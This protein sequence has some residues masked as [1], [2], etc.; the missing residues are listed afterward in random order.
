MAERI[1]VV[2]DEV[3]LADILGKYLQ[4]SGYEV[5]TIY[6]GGEALAAISDFSPALVVL[7]LMLP[8]LNGISICKQV[9]QTSMLPIVMTTAKVEEVDRLL[10]LELGADDYICKPYS[11][12]EVVARVKAILRRVSVMQ[13]PQTLASQSL[14]LEEETLFAGFHGQ[15]VSLTHVE[16]Q[17]LYKLW[18]SPGRIYN[19]EQLMD[20][21]Y[22]DDRIVSDRTIDSHIKKVR[23][24]L[25]EIAPE[26]EFIH[27]IY[28]VGYKFEH[29]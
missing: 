10:G 24:K 4:Q 27:S 20:S 5:K 1:L 19:R 22:D 6:D 23:K 16:F 3:K 12:R 2:E 21:I 15:R 9:R 7:D 11:P 29:V 17:L 26:S 18:R 14:T 28:G 8:N 25:A 13:S